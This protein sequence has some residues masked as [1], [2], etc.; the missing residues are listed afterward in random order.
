MGEIWGKKGEKERLFGGKTQGTFSCQPLGYQ[1]QRVSQLVLTTYTQIVTGR[2]QFPFRALI[3]TFSPIVDMFQELLLLFSQT[4][5]SYLFDFYLSSNESSN[6][7][8]FSSFFFQSKKKI[9]LK[10]SRCVK[11][12]IDP[13]GSAW[14]EKCQKLNRNKSNWKNLCSILT[15]TI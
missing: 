14:K 5:T 15:F 13:V 3:R 8:F 9:G 10:A 7:T 1:F 6:P 12:S 2:L 11:A 4:H